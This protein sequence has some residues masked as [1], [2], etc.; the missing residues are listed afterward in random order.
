MASG[1]Y[2]SNK[3]LAGKPFQRRF[4]PP[5]LGT[6][7]RVG[8]CRT[9]KGSYVSF[10]VRDETPD[11]QGVVEVVETTFEAKAEVQARLEERYGIA[12]P[13]RR[14]HAPIL[15]GRIGFHSDGA[16]HSVICL[17]VKDEVASLLF[18]TSSPNWN[19]FSRPITREEVG[20]LGYTWND[21]TYLAPVFRD[22]REV[23][24]APRFIPSYRLEELRKEFF[25]TP[26]KLRYM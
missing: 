2:S 12:A 20:F 24:W 10:L 19:P 8:I 3:W 15:E 26:E 22:V 17:G 1:E 7:Y 16:V 5:T 4:P 9:P 21:H 11:P 18:V 25:S 23:S 14:V 6:R 13:S